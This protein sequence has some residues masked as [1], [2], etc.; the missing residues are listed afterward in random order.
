MGELESRNFR[1]VKMPNKG[2]WLLVRRPGVAVTT[3]KQA[4]A[5]SIEKWQLIVKFMLKRPRSYLDS[6]G[7]MTCALCALYSEDCTRREG[8]RNRVLLRCPVYRASGYDQCRSTP[9]SMGC[10]Q[11]TFAGMEV[12]FL[13]ALVPGK[14][15]QPKASGLLRNWELTDYK[16]G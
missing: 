16:G 11:L 13:K 8:R 6:G 10:Q 4:I 5:L 3:E 12:M 14:K 15:L 1:V 2:G 9:Y 7:A